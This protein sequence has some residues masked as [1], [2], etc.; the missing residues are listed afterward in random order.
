MGRCVAKRWESGNTWTPENP[1]AKLPRLVQYSASNSQNY[2]DNSFWL[3]D[4]SFLRIKNIQIGYSLPADILAK[5]KIAGLRV[6]IDAQ[7]AFTFTKFE[8][9]DPA[10][11]RKFFP[12]S[13]SKCSDYQCRFELKILI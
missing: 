3:Q 4:A 8:G 7:N 6:Y 10:R 1:N 13:I 2:A 12:S 9:L 11:S 5:L